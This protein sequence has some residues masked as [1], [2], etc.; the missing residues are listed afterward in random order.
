[1]AARVQLDARGL[2]CP[3]PTL[4]MTN[5]IMK[6][7]VTPGDTLAIVADCPT[8]EAD[9]RNWCNTMKKVLILYKEEGGL[10]K[11]EIRI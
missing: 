7:E 1:M 10:K 2:K 3:T 6:K 4:M 11:A 5:S 8:F 9:V